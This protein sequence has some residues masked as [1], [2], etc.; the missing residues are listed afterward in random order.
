[1]SGVGVCFSGCGPRYVQDA[2]L[3]AIFFTPAPSKK[4]RAARGYH[5]WKLTVVLYAAKQ[6][7]GGTLHVHTPLQP[8]KAGNPI[9]ERD[10]LAI[11]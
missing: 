4:L 5:A 2:D 10:D 9:L 7:G 8:C 3:Y 11:R 6:I 1:V